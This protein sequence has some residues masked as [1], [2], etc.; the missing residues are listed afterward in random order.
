MKLPWRRR[1]TT[2]SLPSDSELFCSISYDACTV[3]FGSF[4]AEVYGSFADPNGVSVYNSSA[5]LI[6]DT[7]HHR[8]QLC[9]GTSSCTVDA[10]DAEFG[11]DSHQ[12]NAPLKTTWYGEDM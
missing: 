6:T 11:S 7:D 10:G 2:S 8:V 1:G 12:L 4:G 9:D 3:L 5:Y